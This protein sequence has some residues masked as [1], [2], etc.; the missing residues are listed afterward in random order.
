MDLIPPWIAK[1][2]GWVVGD[3]LFNGCFWYPDLHGVELGFLWALLL[4]LDIGPV[5]APYFKEEESSRSA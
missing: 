3:Q 5:S 1:D 4:P 2:T